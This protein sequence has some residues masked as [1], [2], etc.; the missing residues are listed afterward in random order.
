MSQSLQ[1]STELTAGKKRERWTLQI[2]SLRC[3]L[4]LVTMALA[5]R[6]N[7]E[8]SWGDEVRKPLRAI[9]NLLK[10]KVSFKNKINLLT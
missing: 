9:Q 5:Q 2:N 10:Y 1:F 8:D 4:S 6:A 3:R 7:G